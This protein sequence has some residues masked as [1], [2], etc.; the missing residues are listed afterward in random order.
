VLSGEREAQLAFLGATHDL[1]VLADKMPSSSLFLVLDIGGGS[2]ELIA[3]RESQILY[4]NSMDIGAVRLKEMFLA[5]D[6]STSDEVKGTTDYIKEILGAAADE[7]RGSAW[8]LKKANAFFIGVAGTITTIAAVKQKMAVYDAQR[9]HHSRLGEADVKDVLAEFLSKDLG[10]RKKIVGLEPGR[11]DVIIAGTLI[12][13]S[14]MESLGFHEIIV[15]ES[16]ILDGLILSFSH[17][18]TI[19]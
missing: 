19:F 18:N 13:L 4:H 1:P 15:S 12:A 10:E 8:W 11:A 6:P 2:T 5:S 9:I 16:D 14:A 17:F 3:G 7:I